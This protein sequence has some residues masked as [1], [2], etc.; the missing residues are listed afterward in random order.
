L[1][2]IGL[3]VEPPPKGIVAL[4]FIQADVRNPVLAELLQSEGVQAVCHLKFVPTIRPGRV[5]MEVNV[6][7]A[8]KV[9]DACAEAGVDQVVL[10]SS[11]AVYGAHPDNSAFL[12]E[13]QTLRGS[14][15]YGYTKDML[16]IESLCDDFR[17]R[18]PGTA[19]T[20]LRFASIVGPIADTPMTR[21]LKNA[22]APALMGFDPTMQVVHEDDV[23]EALAHV[24]IDAVPGVFNVAA[25]GALPLQRLMALAGKL[26]LT[27]PHPPLYWG[28]EALNSG[29]LRLGRYLPIEPDYLRYPW[30]GDLTKMRGELGFAPYYTAEEALREF[31]EHPAGYRYGYGPTALAHDEERLRD[32]IERRRRARKAHSTTPVGEEGK[33]NE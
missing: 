6:G 4:D 24:I 10:K 11:L 14:R 29:R 32:T 23:V 21:F 16:E 33:D 15:R 30:V 22:L 27:V 2:V 26:S 9:L 13:E 1:H 5:A 18:A 28:V 20:I 7:G 19:L 31:A 8:L 12:T 17:R 3:D 25:E